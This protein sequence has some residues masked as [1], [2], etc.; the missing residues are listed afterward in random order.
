MQMS[1]K[2]KFE[3]DPD[4]EKENIKKHHISFSTAKLAF[5]DPERFERYDSKHSEKDD[6][7]QTLGLV[8]QLLFVVYTERGDYTQLITARLADQDERRV[9]NGDGKRDLEGWTKAN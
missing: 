6:R 1:S 9:Y 3:W 8:D 4:K 2:M 7:W 5:N